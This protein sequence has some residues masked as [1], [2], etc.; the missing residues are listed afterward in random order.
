VFRQNGADAMQLLKQ[1]QWVIDI[2]GV[3]NTH[4][5]VNQLRKELS[6]FQASVIRQLLRIARR[7]KGDLK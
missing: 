4:P 3:H 7:E 5:A 1:A 6:S 2:S